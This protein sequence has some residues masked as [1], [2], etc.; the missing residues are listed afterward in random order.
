LEHAGDFVDDGFERI[1]VFEREAEQHGVESCVAARQRFSACADVAR[2][3]GAVSGDSDLRVCRVES[4][5]LDPSR[6]EVSG[7][8]ALP[9]PYI[10]R[11]SGGLEMAR[12]QWEDL[13]LVFGVD[14]G[15]VLS[16]PP[17]GVVLP[18]G[19]VACGARLHRSL[20]LARLPVILAG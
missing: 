17:L 20:I 16:L 3:A 1:D 7:N 5:D 18:Q 4:G 13:L 12:D 6:G 19:F 8:L 10:E 15:R 9:A 14:A 11:A 2:P